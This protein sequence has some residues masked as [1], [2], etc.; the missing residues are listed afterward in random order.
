MEG[1][2]GGTRSSSNELAGLAR[3]ASRT[4]QPVLSSSSSSSSYSMVLYVHRNRKA[5]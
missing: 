2:G 4:G 5:Y 3:K 1:G